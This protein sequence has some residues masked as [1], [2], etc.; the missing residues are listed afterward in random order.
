MDV[1]D[2]ALVGELGGVCG[3]RE[4]F[5]DARQ[6]EESNLGER[7][8]EITNARIPGRSCSDEHLPA[9]EP[10][11]ESDKHMAK[12]RKKEESESESE[13]AGLSRVTAR[14]KCGRCRALPPGSSMVSMSVPGVAQRTGGVKLRRGDLGSQI[15][16]QRSVLADHA[17]RPAGAAG[18]VDDVARLHVAR[19]SIRRRAGVRA[20]G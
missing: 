10:T 19:H 20:A 9:A 12:E 15:A 14:V 6:S 16:D 7:A 18:G 11:S 3:R 17:L 2:M 5:C 4:R 8:E 1:Y 13:S